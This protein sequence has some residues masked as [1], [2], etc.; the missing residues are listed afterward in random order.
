MNT[1][2]T[3]TIIIT[4]LFSVA[5][6]ISLMIW[7]MKRTGQKFWP[8][9][10]GAICFA[11][12]AMVLENLLHQVCLVNENA[13][14]KA[15][16]GS[17][18][19]YSLYAAFAAGIFEETGRLFG[20]KVLLRRHDEKPCAV[21]YGI[22]HGG[23]EVLLILGASYVVLLL[24]VLGVDF[25]GEETNAQLLETAKGAASGTAYIAMLERISAMLIHIGLSMLVFV[26][27]RDKRRFW[28]YPAAICIHALADTPAA[29]YQYKILNSLFA[30]E[31]AALVMGIICVILGS[32]VLRTADTARSPAETPDREHSPE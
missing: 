30:V 25:G 21:A 3:A 12:F 15:I 18:V 8:F 17:P 28:L 9:A 27:A 13:V 10:A 31:G 26:A 24:A 14:S 32:R 16:L 1:G 19:L 23:C 20:F 22:G 6:P 5:L 29:L 2:V 4:V 7:W 11:L